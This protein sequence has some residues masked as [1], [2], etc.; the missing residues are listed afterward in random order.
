L[1][2]PRREGQTGVRP[3]GEAGSLTSMRSASPQSR[4]SE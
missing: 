4:S 1:Q 3:S 2:K